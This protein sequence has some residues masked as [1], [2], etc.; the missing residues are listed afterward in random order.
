MKWIHSAKIQKI[1]FLLLLNASAPSIS[2]HTSMRVK[3]L[4]LFSAPK[5][6]AV[7]YIVRDSGFIKEMVLESYEWKNTRCFPF[8][9]SIHLRHPTI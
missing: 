7:V 5:R 8:A 2:R 9:A 1:P 6:L 3:Y 4:R